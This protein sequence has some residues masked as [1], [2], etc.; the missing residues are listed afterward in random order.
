MKKLLTLLTIVAAFASTSVAQTC[1]TLFNL[2][3][4]LDTPTYY[5]GSVTGAPDSGYISGNN[6]YGDLQKAE[7]F[8]AA[9]GDTLTSAFIDFAIVA[10]NPGDSD[11]TVTILAY[12]STG[13]GG[14]PGNAFDSAKITYR[15]ITQAVTLINSQ[16]A[17]AAVPVS[18]N[19]HVL[20]TS[21]FYIS[22]VLPD[23]LG[24]TLAVY[25]NEVPPGPDGR[26]WEYGVGQSGYAWA[27]ITSDWGF[28]GG[29]VGLYIAAGVCVPAA[30]TATG[31][32]QLSN[33]LQVKVYPNPATDV[34]NLVWNQ[35][36][37]ADLAIID[38]KG[39]VLSTMTV[40]GGM[41]TVY[42]I[43][44]LAAGA[45]ILRITDKA[46]NL[47]QSTLITKF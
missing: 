18:F 17:F 26:A 19:N 3:S 45:Y 29:N 39:T 10:V 21:G 4:P 6:I 37:N 11:K 33:N 46:T 22:V 38:M 2:V 14:A 27:S 35:L 16:T 41:Q 9:V 44:N 15:Q 20:P 31:I 32:V 42:N 34:I 30:D 43:H 7:E 13:A 24:D 12:D 25:Q 1:D 28:T 5:F 23:T 8:S 36:T 47:Q 40:S